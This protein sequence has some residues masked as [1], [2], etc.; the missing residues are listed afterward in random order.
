MYEE[1]Y[2]IDYAHNDEASDNDNL[3][4]MKHYFVEDGDSLYMIDVDW[5]IRKY[6]DGSET[7][8]NDSLSIHDFMHRIDTDKQ[9]LL[10]LKE[11]WCFYRSK[12]DR[13]TIEYFA[14]HSLKDCIEHYCYVE[15]R[16]TFLTENDMTV[17]Y[18]LDK[19]SINCF[20]NYG[21]TGYTKVTKIR[22][23]KLLPR[24]PI[25]EAYDI[26]N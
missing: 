18:C 23:T 17:I 11:K 21:K 6:K 25:S 5:V 4:D 1:L 16:D 19:H 3:S 24:V 26:Y 9:F 10:S 13:S 14:S 8:I 15:G 7:P 2:K 12:T 20:F 22:S